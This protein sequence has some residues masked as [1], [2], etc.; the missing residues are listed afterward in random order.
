MSTTPFTVICVSAG[1][2]DAA[3]FAGVEA[4]P[5]A[6]FGGNGRATT[7]NAPRPRLPTMRATAGTRSNRR[8][9]NTSESILENLREILARVPQVGRT[10]SSSGSSSERIRASQPALADRTPS[11]VIR[12]SISP[13]R[14]RG[15]PS[16][17]SSFARFCWHGFGHRAIGKCL[18]KC[19]HYNVLQSIS[20]NLTTCHSTCIIAFVLVPFGGPSPFH[21]G[22]P[23]M[24]TE[25]L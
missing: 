12:L 25:G 10:H 2:A 3:T 18:H 21:P 6:N 9:T 23:A 22:T 4:P 1:Q 24:L 20:N 19:L 5:P 16:G 14:R 13:D 7:N 15:T 11:R 8:F 17:P